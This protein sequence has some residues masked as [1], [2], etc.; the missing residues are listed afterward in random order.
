MASAE[1]RR[2]LVGSNT[3]SKL[4]RVLEIVNQYSNL[5]GHASY[6]VITRDSLAH[7]LVPTTIQRMFLVLVGYFY[8]DVFDPKKFWCPVEGKLKVS[9]SSGNS[10]IGVVL[11]LVLVI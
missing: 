6:E 9:T 8:F 2:T 1:S 10:S 4:D 3:T 5:L 11:V 7:K